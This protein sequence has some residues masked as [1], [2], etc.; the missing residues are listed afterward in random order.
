VTNKPCSV[1]ALSKLYDLQDERLSQIQV[2]GDLIVPENPS[3]RIMTRSRARQSKRTSFQ[4]AF[5]NCNGSIPLSQLRCLQQEYDD[6][7]LTATS[8][9]DPDQYTLVPASLKILK[10]LIEELQAS[11]GANQQLSAEQ[12]AQLEEADSDDGDWEDDPDAVDLGSASVKAE[13]MVSIAGKIY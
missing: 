11:S 9:T 7:P 6:R 3:G 2:K 12:I 10:V 13:M 5:F 1:I 8:S 4:Q